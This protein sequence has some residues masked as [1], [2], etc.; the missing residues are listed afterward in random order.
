MCSTSASPSRAPT[1]S[2]VP[3]LSTERIT[4]RYRESPSGIA[5]QAGSRCS[6]SRTTSGASPSLAPRKIGD[7]LL[8]G[9]RAPLEPA[10]RWLGISRD[11]RR[12]LAQFGQQ[13]RLSQARFADHR[14]ER[15]ASLAHLVQLVVHELEFGV[16]A[17][18]R[19]GQSLE[20][21]HL[22]R[23]CLGSKRFIGL[24]RRRLAFDRRRPTRLEYEELFHEVI[25]ISADQNGAGHGSSLH[26]GCDVRG[27]AHGRV[28]RPA[29]VPY[30]GEHRQPRVDS[31]AHFEVDP[32][33]PPDLLG[34][35]AG[36]RLDIQTRA[37]S[38]FGVV[39]V[40]DRR[41]EKREDRIAK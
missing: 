3:S 18:Q 40:G 10:Y 25:G 8:V 16:T 5:T 34:V 17:Y 33:V 35:F 28:F 13:P 6:F 12:Q 20:A 19:R 29:L 15:A 41:T 39:F 7:G 21:S 1:A 24:Y 37:Y 2:R 27:I 30:G 22:A 9:E 38:A 31:D 4:S 32:V 36:G 11:S 23:H 14:H 26:S